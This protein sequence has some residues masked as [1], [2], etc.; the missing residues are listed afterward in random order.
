MQ[1]SSAVRCKN[2]PCITCTIDTFITDEISGEFY[3]DFFSPSTVILYIHAS[4]IHLKSFRFAR[5]KRRRV[6][7]AV[8]AEQQHNINN[9]IILLS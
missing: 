8:V 6:F 5:H 4:V 9:I 1:K 3:F 7:M 2:L